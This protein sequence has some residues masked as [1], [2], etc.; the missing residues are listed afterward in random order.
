MASATLR[1]HPPTWLRQVQ[2]FKWALNED[3]SNDKLF[4]FGGRLWSSLVIRMHKLKKTHE[5]SF[6]RILTLFGSIKEVFQPI[7]VQSKIATV[8]VIGIC[9]PGWAPALTAP[10]PIGMIGLRACPSLVRYGRQAPTTTHAFLDLGCLHRRPPPRWAW[11]VT[12][13][14]KCTAGCSRKCSKE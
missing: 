13:K 12:S 8:A 11:K 5:D 7:D 14:S 2:A 6:D 3:R 9:A 4:M 1:E 10:S